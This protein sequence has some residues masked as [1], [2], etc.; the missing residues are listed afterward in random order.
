M[1]YYALLNDNTVL[2]NFL[3]V[4]FDETTRGENKAAPI[5]KETLARLRV[6]H[7]NAQIAELTGINVKTVE[8]YA[9]KYNLPKKSRI[10][11]TRGNRY[12]K[13]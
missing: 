5:D 10:S 8:Y 9:K 3:K 4:I 2:I 13:N 12:D 7:S 1:K 6:T 11:G